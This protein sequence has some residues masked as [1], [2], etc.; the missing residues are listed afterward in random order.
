MPQSATFWCALF[1]VVP[2]EHQEAI[3]IESATKTTMFDVPSKMGIALTALFDFLVTIA[4]TTLNCA[5]I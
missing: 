4:C 2:I 5:Y 3:S 1:F